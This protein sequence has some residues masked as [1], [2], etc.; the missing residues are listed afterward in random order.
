VAVV[1]TLALAALWGMGGVAQGG[2]IT[3]TTG[4]FLPTYLGAKN[5]AFDVVS[6]NGTF[7]GTTF[8][9]TADL[10]GPVS[11]APAGSKPVYVWG[12]NTGTGTLNFANIANPNV[13]FNTVAT[14]DAAGVTNKP[15]IYVG[16]ISGNKVSIDI[17]LSALPPSTG[18]APQDYLWNLWPRDISAP[19]DAT[20]GNATAIADFAPDNATEGFSLVPEPSTLCL[21]SIGVAGL[22]GCGYYRK[23]R[24]AGNLSTR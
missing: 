12:I 8:R 9:L 24:R 16:S 17:P 18:F 20:I 5:G 23:P 1:F 10:A 4:D 14:L 2:P 19:L 3:D 7:D 21:L 11:G 13:K 22:T 6:A 15:G